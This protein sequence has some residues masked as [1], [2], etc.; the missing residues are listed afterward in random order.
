[1]RTH[2]K[3]NIRQILSGD[4]MEVRK[5]FTGSTTPPAVDNIFDN[6]HADA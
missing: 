2:R 3:R 6:M 1:M 4:Q 5:F